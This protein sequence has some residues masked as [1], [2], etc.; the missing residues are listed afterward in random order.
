MLAQ[1]CTCQV[2]ELAGTKAILCRNIAAVAITKCDSST[3]TS[4]QCQM[5]TEERITSTTARKMQSQ[6]STAERG[7][8]SIMS[9]KMY[10]Q[11]HAMK[12]NN[13]NT[14][15]R[16]NGYTSDAGCRSPLRT[17]DCNGLD[18]KDVLNWANQPTRELNDSRIRYPSDPTGK[19]RERIPSQ[20]NDKGAINSATPSPCNSGVQQDMGRLLKEKDAELRTLRETMTKNENAILRVL[21]DKKKFWEADLMDR[22]RE[23]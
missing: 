19:G 8:I 15:R 13:D 18:F 10:D 4:M 16:S 9:P 14:V 20:S 23:K 12:T 17:S 22:N 7:N 3:L 2:A 21:E 11:T 6:L 5:N 1:C